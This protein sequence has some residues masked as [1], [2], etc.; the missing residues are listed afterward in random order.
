MIFDKL[1][2]PKWQNKDANIRI[3]ALN[4]FDISNN[5]QQ[6]ILNQLINEDPSELVRRASLI[7]LNTAETWLSACQQ[8]SNQSIRQFAEGKVQA[9]I[10]TANDLSTAFKEN[11]LNICSK[12][13]FIEQ[14]L[15][16]EHDDKLL[17]K[18][19]K[20]V[21][22]PNILSQLLLKTDNNELQDHVL[23]DINE[24]E[25]LE[26]LLKKSQSKPVHLKIE[27]KVT[28]LRTVLDKPVKLRKH[29][30]L[31][32]SKLLALKDIQNYEEML[33]RKLLIE[34]DWQNY[35]TEFACL[36]KSEQQV[37]EE[38]YAHINGQL[39]KNFIVLEE[40]YK[41]Q[42]II[43]ALELKQQQ[44]TNQFNTD[45]QS[46]A[47]SITDAVFDNV[48]LDHQA[49]KNKLAHLAQQIKESVVSDSV[50]VTFISEVEKLE[51]KL[52]KLPEV[53]QSVSAA[54][55]LIA[56][57]SGLALPTSMLEFNER[58]PLFDD[59]NAQWQEINQLANDILP[60]SLTKA[61]DELQHTWLT[62]MSKYHKQQAQAFTHF[63]KKMS[64]LRRLISYGKYKSA[65]GLYKKLTFLLEEFSQSNKD[66]LEQDF[67]VLSN[68]IQEL[69]ELESF[70]VTPKKQRLLSEIQQF[71][72]EPLDNPAQQAEKVKLF[73]KQ[74][75]LL[76]H[77]DELLD[78]DLNND[79]NKACEEA[80]APCRQFYAEQGKL[81]ERHLLEKQN[82]LK[83]IEQ[84]GQEIKL[85]NVNWQSIDAKLSKLMAKW[86]DT[87]EV[88]RSQYQ[89]LYKKYRTLVDPIKQGIHF[90][91]DKNVILKQALIVKAKEYAQDEDVF[92]AINAL[93]EIQQNWRNI[94]YAGPQ[95]ENQLWQS[96]R[97]VN[98][99]LFAKRDS[100][101]ES[102][103]DAQTQEVE[104]FKG[105]LSL[106]SDKVKS[107]QKNE[108]K[109]LT[110]E[111]NLF[112]EKVSALKSRNKIL[113]NDAQALIK[114]LTIHIE[115][116]ENAKR[117]E[118]TNILFNVL[119]L[120][121]SKQHSVEELT[122]IVGF[123]D[124]SKTVQKQLIH[125]LTADKN[126][127]ARA[128][129]TIE[130]EILAKIMSPEKFA[131]Q[132]RQIQVELL[133]DKLNQGEVTFSEKFSQ[134]LTCASF[135]GT[136]TEIIKRARSSLHQG[137]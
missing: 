136:D 22:K 54:T 137:A 11:Y 43:A 38:K 42:Q 73:R 114:Q 133:A 14:W 7:K 129:L 2:K 12:S 81:R 131:D 94:G 13:V 101:V 53:A 9:L 33:Q 116:H 91:Q 127:E 70:V 32:L 102:Q 98:D 23:A 37:F 110:S 26:K 79:F 15:L 134:W 135:T 128:R 16:V 60:E 57:F 48:E 47:Q 6:K 35:L 67:A 78:K 3:S 90:F 96:F 29:I 62:T 51:F 88:D 68:N 1:F 31:T 36:E 82:V 18:L 97:K 41:Q 40:A 84:L 55:A 80:F 83:D 105:E 87:G 64:E 34:Q 115:E 123:N 45:I 44:Q 112:I 113:I 8:N 89:A 52:T 5:E 108:I 120:L 118:N 66:R 92:S 58:K 125:T 10:L 72:N 107:V 95:K 65:F 74:W 106:L 93:K 103:K 19:L 63:R 28:A 39:K 85:E 69:H 17:A 130:L 124:L 59:W 4:E 27:N 61:R 30:Q 56:K 46:I 104:R 99:Q 50:K 122:C 111:I 77:A 21:N 109:A 76:G 126:E 86:R 71:V 20:K 117:I 100:L 121:S 49:V 75:N 24:L 119:T 25:V 132:R